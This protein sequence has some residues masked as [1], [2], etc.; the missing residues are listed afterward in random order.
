MHVEVRYREL[1]REREREGEREGG[2]RSGESPPG[3]SFSLSVNVPW[4]K[5]RSYIENGRRAQRAMIIG[6]FTLGA[7]SK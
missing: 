3:F 2:E 5:R 6:A 1:E 4:T 7:F